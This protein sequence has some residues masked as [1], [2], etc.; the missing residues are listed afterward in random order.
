L[1]LHAKGGLGDVFIARDEQLHREVALKQL[2]DRHADRSESRLRFLFE[3][4]VTGSL[5]HPGIVPVYGLGRYPDGRPYYAMRLIDG[6]SL[7]EVINN[8]HDTKA[9]K[10]DLGGRA[11]EFRKLLRRFQDV[12]NTIAF[13]H[14]RGVIHRDIKPSNI[15]VGRFGETLVVDW[16]LAKTFT[17]GETSDGSNRS[18]DDRQFETL[19][20][21]PIGT[22][23]YMSP[24]QAAGQIDR[25]GPSSDV[26]SLGATLYHLLTGRTSFEGDDLSQIIERVR[27]GQFSPPHRI[28]RDVPAPLAM[29]CLKA[30]A[31]KPENRYSTPQALANDIDH[32]LAGEPVSVYREWFVQRIW[33]W[34]KIHP[35]VVGSV[36]VLTF[37]VISFFLLSA[38]VLA[39]PG[40]LLA[41]L[42]GLV[43]SLAGAF[44]GEVSQGARQGSALAF[45]IGIAVGAVLFLLG[46]GYETYIVSKGLRPALDFSRPD[47]EPLDGYRLA[48]NRWTNGDQI[49]ARSWFEWAEKESRK[50]RIDS[51]KNETERARL[52]TRSLLYRDE[53]PPR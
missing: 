50:N 23:S 5:E 11:I 13:A 9:P 29:I 52:E 53:T 4:E 38:F 51:R 15:M 25:L 6:S 30:M 33:R 40:I 19:V 14:S 10:S 2:K 26:Y 17:N 22:P 46:F 43:G 41:V 7:K 47:L 27:K 35:W 20:G 24:E 12:C 34:G 36:G 28:A 3:A 45:R 48:A 37:L 31:L 49:G 42:G 39:I 44:R 32:W 18:S 16:G 21:A 8:F 1:R